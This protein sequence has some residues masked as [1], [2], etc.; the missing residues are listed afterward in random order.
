MREDSD[1]TWYR[2]KVLFSRNTITRD[3]FLSTI[4]ALGSRKVLSSNLRRLSF[5]HFV[6]LLLSNSRCFGSEINKVISEEKEKYLMNSLLRIYRIRPTKIIFNPTAP[7][8]GQI[9][10][11]YIFIVVHSF[12]LEVV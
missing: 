12:I 11:E 7:R 9:E 10:L 6:V 1:V 8:K 2:K 3:R 4:S 5:S